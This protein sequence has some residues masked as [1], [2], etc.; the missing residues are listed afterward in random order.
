M[1]KA[2]ISLATVLLALSCN[3]P[4][5]LQTKT[6]EKVF[7]CVEAPLTDSPLTQT[8][9]LTESI[10]YDSE[11]D[12]PAVSGAAVSVSDGTSSWEFAEREGAPGRYDSPRGFR[13]EMGKTYTLDIECDLSDGTHGHYSAVST[14]PDHGFDI[15]RIDYK[16]LGEPKDST[17]V[18]GVWGKDRP[19]T[20]YFLITTAVNGVMSPTTSLLERSM[21]MPDTY[22]NNSYVA[23]FPIAYLYQNS[24]QFKKYGDCAKPLEEGDFVSMVVYTLSKE[25][26]DFITALSTAASG[27]SIPV[28]SSQPANIPTNIKG[29]DA[30]GYFATCPLM[31]VSCM[32][33]DPYKKEFAY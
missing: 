13:C 30:V 14:M 15:D 29:G 22:F 24:Y 9:R 32:I 8:V 12:V 33:E 23:G 26:Y 19:V 17:W 10:D 27:V 3:E 11:N 1:K 18:L 4:F 5:D 2:L 7:L 16:S 25:Y 20:N 6:L 31:I 28:I 21:L